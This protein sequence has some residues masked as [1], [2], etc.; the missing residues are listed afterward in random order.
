MATF[1]IAA[2]LAHNDPVSLIGTSANSE[3]L[4]GFLRTAL[5]SETPLTSS[6]MR[7]IGILA[8]SHTG[9]DLLNSWKVLQFLTDFLKSE[10]SDLRSLAVLALTAVSAALPESECMLKSIPDLFQLAR[11]PSLKSYPLICLSNISVDAVNASACIPYLEELFEHLNSGPPLSVQRALVTIHRVFL[12]PEAL[13]M[14][15]SS[16]LVEKFFETVQD[17]WG[18]EHFPILLDI[19][20]NVSATP[21]GRQWMTAH[22]ME[23]TARTRL[24]A[25]QLDDPLRPKLIRFRARLMSSAD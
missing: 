25:C 2:L 9:I 3:Q 19:A 14:A 24:Q 21:T 12:T 16:S 6:A 10:S 15:E 5:S 11:D 23:V 13:S 18:T 17:W 7:I 4:K 22:G 8:N 1:S 20:E